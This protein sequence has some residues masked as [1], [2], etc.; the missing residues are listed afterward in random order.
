MKIEILSSKII[1]GVISASGLVKARDKYYVIS[2]DAPF[3]YTLDDNYDVISQLPIFTI[4]ASFTSRIEK[5]EKP[6]FEALDIVDD[7]EI[8]AFGSGSKSPER[9]VF[10]RIF[11]KGKKEIKTYQISEFYTHLKN[12]EVMENREL[13]IEAV[14]YKDGQIFIFNRGQNVVFGFVFKELIS[15]FEGNIP[16]PTPR[17]KLFQLPNIRGIRAGFSGATA[18][19]EHPYII[20]TAS[21]ED[22]PNAYDDGEVLGSFIGILK[23]EDDFI[24][25]EFQ[26]VLFPTVEKL[27]VESVIIKQEVELG[28][29][30]IVVVTDDDYKDSLIIECKIWWESFI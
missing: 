30:H 27:K 13:N 28:E 5:S 12:L 2:D 21:V 6:D 11:I 19:K 24:S 1:D 7:N 15:Y 22:T 26:T 29:T 18:L 3:L 20:F 25:S 10:L 17:T 8:I 4:D 16:F 9:D 14:A 23:I